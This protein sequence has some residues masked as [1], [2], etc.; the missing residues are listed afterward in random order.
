MPSVENH[1]L[2]NSCYS[3]LGQI[4][5]E[6]SLLQISFHNKLTSFQVQGETLDAVIGDFR[7]GFVKEGSF[8]VAITRIRNGNNLFLRDFHP[9]YAKV[10]RDVNN[11]ITDM[12][13]NKQYSFFKTYLHEPCFKIDKNDIK[14]GYLNINS[15]KDTLHAEYVNSDK[16]LLNLDFLCISDTR[17]CSKDTEDDIQQ[18]LSNW[19]VVYRK[20]SSDNRQ[21]MGL[22]VIRP[23][24]EGKRVIHWAM[25]CEAP[26][27]LRTTS[28][29]TRIQL[30]H[31]HLY[32]EVIT[33]IYCNQTPSKGEVAYICRHTSKS[34][35]IL[36]D[37]NLNAE[38]STQ[39][40]RLNEIC[41]SSKI[42]HLRAV[43]TVRRNQL[44]HIII[45]R[46]KKYKTSS[47]SYFNFVSDHKS[48]VIRISQYANDEILDRKKDI[49]EICSNESDGEEEFSDT[50]PQFTTLLADN[51][52]N[53][54]VVN[55][56]SQLLMKKYKGI[57][58][59]SSYFCHYFFTLKK[60]YKDL[61]VFDKSGGLFN[62]RVVMIPIIHHY[63]WFLCVL[64]YHRNLLYILDPLLD[65]DENI[66]EH[67]NRQHLDILNKLETDFLAIHIRKKYHRHL[68]TLTKSVLIPPEIPEQKDSS[69]CGVYMLQFERCLSM[70]VP[71]AFSG[72]HMA[73]L[74][75]LIR[76]ELM[77]QCISEELL[78]QITPSTF[79]RKISNYD[80]ET[81]WLN[82]LLQ[83][84]L[85][86]LDYNPGHVLSSH[87]GKMLQKS[88]T[89]TLID[90][91]DFKELIQ[92]EVLNN[93]VRFQEILNDEQD[94]R[95]ALI[96]LTE[97]S[98]SW[99]DVYDLIF[100]TTQTSV[101]CQACNRKSEG[102]SVSQQL[103]LDI[104]CPQDNTSI[105]SKLEYVTNYGEEVP[106]TC[107]YCQVKGI[108]RRCDQIITEASSQFLI[109]CV[110]RTSETY[111][112]NVKATDDITLLDS[113]NCPR[114]YSP[115]NIIHHRGGV[116]PR[117]GVTRHYLCDTKFRDNNQW[118][119]SSDAS[120]P[121]RLNEMEVTSKAYIILYKRKIFSA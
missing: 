7:D 76:H 5:A 104:P 38:I 2:I 44:D 116:Q 23:I 85:C 49:V 105:K 107:E 32:E 48:V 90:S 71:F 68:D 9:G 97:N 94:T 43:T 33:F 77:E 108:G 70:D 81:C 58:I 6:L 25:K 1:S 22:L 12:R 119:R 8:Y 26:E 53:D 62:C 92:N 52:L 67:I 17:L 101:T 28:G 103:Y 55:G 100:N 121:T 45:D 110:Q 36:G 82:V 75:R 95:D 20:D 93:E 83:L 4:I 84:L 91:R 24:V 29:G 18:L 66:Q 61:R 115:V 14:I 50:R 109:V 63:H 40:E 99:P 88:Q 57:F 16:N 102:G 46:D 21:H 114:V 80:S 3:L 39:M 42:L 64:E 117:P 15:L 72:S 65:E 120:E 11:K 118:Y 111:E 113:E 86:A 19:L 98:Q 78:T 35:Y 87:M 89:Q 106:Y 79:S 37:F 73:S 27:D 74:R 69:N 112:N 13:K 56:F 31:G 60:D 34:N 30:I 41:G 51:W 96:I 59:F 47:D 54:D 10:S